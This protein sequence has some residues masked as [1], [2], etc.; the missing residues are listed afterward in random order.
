MKF[1]HSGTY[2]ADMDL[3]ELS[4]RAAYRD[5]ISKY[6]NP[7]QAPHLVYSWARG[8][9]KEKMDTEEKHLSKVSNSL[10]FRV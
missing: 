7:N 8:W 5:G 6:A 2:D 9:H 1:N 4:G 3:A 10:L